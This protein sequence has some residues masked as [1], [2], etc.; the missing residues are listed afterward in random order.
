MQQIDPINADVQQTPL[1]DGTV[2]ARG[3]TVRNLRLAAILVLVL[4]GLALLPP[5]INVNRYQ[6]RIA[7]SISGSLGRPVHL[8]QVSLSLLPLPGFEIQNLVVDEDPAFGAEPIIRANE[9]RVTLRLS[10]LWRRRV[11]FSTISFTSPS[12]NLVHT[13]DGKWNIEKVLLQAS[14]IDAAPTSQRRAGPTPRFPYIEATDARLNFKLDNEKT[15]FSLV[16]SEFALWSPDPNQWQLRLKARP[17]RTDSSASDT[18]AIELEGTLGRGDSLAHIPVD[19]EGQ[20]RDAPLGEASRVLTGDDAGWRG[21]LVL[22]AHIRGTLGESAVTSRL[23]LLGAR[24][25]DFV[26]QQPLSANVECFATATS[27]FHSFVDLRCSWPPGAADGPTVALVGEIPDVRHPQT[28][29]LRLGTSGVPAATLVNWLRLG[30]ANI[31]DSIATT[32]TLTA[33]LVHD[34]ATSA[35]WTGEMTLHNGTLRTAADDAPLLNGD[36]ELHLVPAADGT[37]SMLQ[38]APTPILLGGRDP[39]SLNGQFD[40]NGYAMRLSGMA[41]PLRLRAFAG[42]IAPLG[43]GLVKD[44][45]PAAAKSDVDAQAKAATEDTAA[46][47]AVPPV[48]IDLSTAAGWSAQHAWMQT[49][50]S[51]PQAG[52]AKHRR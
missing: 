38:L 1:P 28:A 30:S 23:R 18:G 6:R 36:V 20:W 3:K 49:T 24:R 19:V 12:V 25:A 15:P 52:N 9:V 48:H 45:T 47:G 50:P 35:A 7:T 41:T 51:Q 8:D 21:N 13:S 40:G 46:Q 37:S 26:P 17:A 5:L 14:H 44:E 16:E 39:A 32:G 10:S 43:N 29:A 11:E 2:P 22:S 42:A 31:S 4:L 34:P 33:S 27:V